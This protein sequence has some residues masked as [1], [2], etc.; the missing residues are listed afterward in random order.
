LDDAGG[1]IAV[2]I[3]VQ[4]RAEVLR[5]A[6]IKKRILN[7]SLVTLFLGAARGARAPNISTAFL[8]RFDPCQVLREALVPGFVGN[9]AGVFG[10]AMQV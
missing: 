10:C 2:G 9:D 3:D 8:Y 7:S 6:V 4:K 1:T 5:E